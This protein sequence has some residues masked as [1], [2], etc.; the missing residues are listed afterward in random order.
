MRLR[1]LQSCRALLTTPRQER[2]ICLLCRRRWKGRAPDPPHEMPLWIESTLVSARSKKS[3]LRINGITTGSKLFRSAFIP[4]PCR[5]RI[6]ASPFWRDLGAHRIPGTTRQCF[7]ERR[8]IIRASLSMERTW[9]G[10]RDRSTGR[11][12][13]DG[14]AWECLFLSYEF[15]RCFLARPSS[16][17]PHPE[18]VEGS[19]A[20]AETQ[21]G[22]GEVCAGD[23]LLS[24]RG[25]AAAVDRFARAEKSKL[26]PAAD[27][28]RQRRS[29]PS[30]LPQQG[31][32]EFT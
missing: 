3:P 26:S 6:M 9:S 24:F 10:A 1:R 20:R 18:L 7:V 4:H 22:N 29:A 27:R 17:L 30:L 21:R 28:E 32:K 13:P 31:E 14:R 12:T 11:Q 5:F 25:K 15:V 2:S 19:M 23:S 8:R 16:R